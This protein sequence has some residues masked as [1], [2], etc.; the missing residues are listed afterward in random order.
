ME[1]YSTDDAHLGRFGP[2][3]RISFYFMQ[4]NIVIYKAMGPFN[5][6]LLEAFA[7]VEPGIIEKFQSGVGPWVEVIIFEKSCL[8]MA[9]CIDVFSA[10]LKDMK[11]K[12]LY[13]R[14]SAMVIEPDVEGA[15]FMT[16][17]YQQ[18]YREAG[19]EF[20]LFDNRGDAVRWVKTY[21]PA[22]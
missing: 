11:A 16:K 18:C 2:H 12:G 9:E 13:P 22:P 14:A 10:Y 17:I 7:Q 1:E 3:G 21:L 19:F 4:G 8:A 6:E 15:A 20:R 5:L